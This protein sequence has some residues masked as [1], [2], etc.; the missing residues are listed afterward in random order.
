MEY[1]E[2]V[3]RVVDGSLIV[4]PTDTY[5]LSVGND[6]MPI[7]TLVTI[8]SNYTPPSVGKSHRIIHISLGEA[9]VLIVHREP[10]AFSMQ[11]YNI[12]LG[13][14]P[15]I[16]GRFYWF[17]PQYYDHTS[18]FTRCRFRGL[19]ELCVIPRDLLDA[20]QIDEKYLLN[21][22]QIHG[23]HGEGMRTNINNIRSYLSLD[24]ETMDNTKTYLGLELEV[25]GYSEETL[26]QIDALMAEPSNKDLFDHFDVSHDASLIH[27]GAEFVSLPMS[28]NYIM[29]HRDMFDKIYD[30][31]NRLGWTSGRGSM[32]IHFD[33]HFIKQLLMGNGYKLLNFVWD[34]LA[35]HSRKINYIVGRVGNSWCA[36]RSLESSDISDIKRDHSRWLCNTGRT[37]EIRRYGANLNTDDLFLKI[38]FTMEI[39]E[40]I[41]SFRTLPSSY[42]EVATNVL[43]SIINKYYLQ[44]IDLVENFKQVAEEDNEWDDMFDWWDE[45]TAVRNKRKEE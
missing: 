4:A 23:Y 37:I 17:I 32:H 13:F 33:Y 25:C 22:F 3:K 45:S 2:F 21:P 8:G 5:F 9:S 30:C 6:D 28:Y 14:N 38:N 24:G 39:F 42:M 34:N 29:A 11:V 10:L 31:V 18:Y 12:P 40:R 35:E 36:F 43:L 19:K 27:H 44:K 1:K 41:M 26:N 7:V 16:I 20:V 15:S